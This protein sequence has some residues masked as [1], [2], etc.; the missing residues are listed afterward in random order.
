MKAK[1]AFDYSFEKSKQLVSVSDTEDVLMWIFHVDKI[2]PHIGISSRG[3]FYS[4]K[5]NGKDKV[6]CFKVNQIIENKHIKCIKVKLRFKH[7][8]V[9]IDQV[10][11]LFSSATSAACSCLT[12]IKRALA[13]TANINKLADLLEAL[14]AQDKIEGWYAQNL[15]DTEARIRAYKISDINKRFDKLHA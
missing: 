11:G 10:F 13:M 12:P 15:G 6:A 3:L 8:E 7:S 2:P 1:L 14:D 5:S 4:L 9:P